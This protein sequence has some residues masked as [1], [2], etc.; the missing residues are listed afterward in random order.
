LVGVQQTLGNRAVQR[1]LHHQWASRK[2]NAQASLQRQTTGRAVLNNGDLTAPT[3]V[4]LAGRRVT[5]PAGTYVEVLH[6]VAGGSQYHVRVW[7]GFG[8]RECDIPSNHFQPQPQI[9]NDRRDR[10]DDRVS[11]R[12]VDGP[13]WNGAPALADIDQGAI[14]DCYL[15]AAAGALAQ[16][17][18]Q[19][20]MQ[21]FAPHTPNQARY[22]ITLYRRVSTHAGVQLTPVTYTID[23]QLP[24][25]TQGDHRPSGQLIYAGDAGGRTPAGAA[26]TPRPLW[27]MLLE[28]AYA[29]LRGGYDDIDNDLQIQQGRRSRAVETAQAMEA[30]TG[31]VVGTDNYDPELAREERE[32]AQAI[33][34][35]IPA[36][37]GNPLRL[38][39]AA[40]LARLETYLGQSVPIVLSTRDAPT[41]PNRGH[42]I[43]PSIPGLIV[44]HGYVVERVDR[45]ANRIYLHNPW[46]RDRQGRSTNPPALTAEQVLAFF[47]GITVPDSARSSGP[48]ASG[49]GG[50][51]PTGH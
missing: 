49:S 22:Q 4:A 23:R 41:V 17:N 21:L 13:L 48:Q 45:S 28:K 16:A 39:P 40:F 35:S 24:V 18:P 32:I 42:L 38:P 37:P 1:L 51:P 11:Y 8:G 5:L 30:L 2:A 9:G 6:H 50:G 26:A 34:G 14:G 46:G 33:G 44:N 15:L 25:L 20:I 10:P 29:Q 12:T 47:V 3:P 43:D 19:R 27:P 31:Q 36:D 7:S